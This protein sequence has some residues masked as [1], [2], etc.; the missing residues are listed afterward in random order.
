MLRKIHIKDPLYFSFYL[1][2]IYYPLSIS[3]VELLQRSGKM[4]YNLQ[5]NI[6]KRREV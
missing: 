6:V 1:L 4:K 2:E 3:Y 5:A